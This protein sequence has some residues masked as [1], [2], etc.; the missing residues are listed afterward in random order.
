MKQFLIV[1][2]LTAAL[3]PASAQSPA[4]PTL[5]PQQEL[6]TPGGHHRSKTPAE[7]AAKDADRAEKQ[8]SL[9]ADQKTKWRE[10][11]LA[12]IT[13]NTPLKEKMRASADENEKRSLGQQMRDNGKKFDDTVTGFLTADQ[14]TKWVQVKEE[15][16]SARRHKGKPHPVPAPAPQTK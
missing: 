4:A 8:L 5:A 11:S 16:K 9:N 2:A 7:R 6:K 15:R 3:S 13:A 12:R 1:A 14:K 10:A